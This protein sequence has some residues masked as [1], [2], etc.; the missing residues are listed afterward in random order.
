MQIQDS[1]PLAFGLPNEVDA[2]FNNSPTFRVENGAMERGFTPVAWFGEDP[3]RSGWAW[4]EDYIE[5]G[6]GVVDAS[7]SNGKLLLFGPEIAFRGQ[8][9]GTFKLLFNGIY[10]PRAREVTLGNRNDLVGGSGQSQKRLAI[11]SEASPRQEV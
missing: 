8:S 3:L 9:H 1:H 6:A 2:V 5:G 10:Y 7:V 4:G 11:P